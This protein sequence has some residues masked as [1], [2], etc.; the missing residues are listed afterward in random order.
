VLPRWQTVKKTERNFKKS[1]S[2][3]WH[4]YISLRSIQDTT[5]QIQ[6][7]NMTKIFFFSKLWN[8]SS[9]ARDCQKTGEL[10]FPLP[11]NFGLSENYRRIFFLSEK[12][13]SSG[14]IWGGRIK[15]WSIHNFNCCAAY[16]LADAKSD[17]CYRNNYRY[18]LGLAAVFCGVQPTVRLP[19]ASYTH[20]PQS[21]R[22]FHCP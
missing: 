10:S 20:C 8:S 3:H 18:S 4:N 13:R 19:V 12:F 17:I 1:C 7:V 9:C 11:L 22:R 2:S 15:I 16:F 14:K 6:S 5:N 21:V